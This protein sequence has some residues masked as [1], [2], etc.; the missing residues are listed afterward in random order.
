MGSVYLYSLIK[1][2]DLSGRYIESDKANFGT[3]TIT[4]T[5]ISA[6]QTLLGQQLGFADT[7][8]TRFFSL[9]YGLQYHL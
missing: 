3:E 1:I 6:K 4:T 2:Q 9:V 8:M 5:E 7:G